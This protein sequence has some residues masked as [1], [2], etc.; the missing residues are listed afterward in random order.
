MARVN[1][2]DEPGNTTLRLLESA[3]RTATNNTGTIRNRYHRGL[4]VTL[5]ITVVPAIETVTLTIQG[6][7]PLTGKLYT[8]LASVLEAAAVTIIMRVHPMLT[9][10]ANLIAQDVMPEEWRVLVSHSAAGTFNYSVSA[11]LVD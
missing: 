10:A 11:Q 3:A 6:V 4:I 8:I 1:E 2:N 7:D 9:A 5:D